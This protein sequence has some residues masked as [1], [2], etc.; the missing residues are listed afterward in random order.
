MSDFAEVMSVRN[1]LNECQFVILLPEPRLFP[2]NS[3]FLTFIVT[4]TQTRARCFARQI[5]WSNLDSVEKTV[6]WNPASGYG[7]LA[8]T[9]T[10]FWPPGKNRHTFPCKKT[11]VNTANFF[12]PI[13]DHINWVP[14]N[15][16]KTTL[17]NNTTSAAVKTESKKK[18]IKNL[19]L[20][21]RTY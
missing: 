2:R 11:L 7:H 3:S 10:L 20:K 6:Q 9:A 13:G 18:Y 17:Y 21:F 15:K 4:L 14:L 8:I 1:A 12:W 16:K 19:S 5:F